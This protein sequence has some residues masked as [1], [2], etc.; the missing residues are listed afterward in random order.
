MS[1]NITKKRIVSPS[2][3]ITILA[4]YFVVPSQGAVLAALGQMS[5]AFPDVPGSY[6]GYVASIVALAQIIGAIVSG[7]I[8][9]RFVK[10]KTLLLASLILYLI[11]GLSPYLIPDGGSFTLLLAT[12]FIF[13]LGLGCFKP[14]AE[15]LITNA[16][17][18][19]NKRAN[20][21][22]F[23]NSA[24][25]IGAVIF[26]T[27]GGLLC[28][29][30]WQTTFLVY[31]AGL[32]PLLAVA[33]LFKEPTIE[34]ADELKSKSKIKIPIV[35]W[36]L[37][38][39]FTCTQVFQYPTFVFLGQF[40]L[41]AGFYNPAVAGTLL[42]SITAVSFVVALAFGGIYRLLGKLTLPISALFVAGGELC[43]YF[44]CSTV[45]MPLMILAVV[46]FGIGITI[47]MAGLSQEV[48]RLVNK[49]TAAAALGFLFAFMNVG[50]FL[51]TPYT[52]MVEGA[53][54]SLLSTL[55]IGP[56]A[57]V[58]VGIIYAAIMFTAKPVKGP[59]EV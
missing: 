46:I 40:M 55:V 34:A 10:Y 28:L 20:V 53:T 16:Y 36:V 39:M 50:T 29:I 8:V 5:V 24:F 48:S 52:V 38:I 35:V 25:S 22:G 47:M 32:V 12:R 43:F 11:A 31:L 57:L 19:E 30:S 33:F 13:G 45:S 6:L 17:K 1:E 14:V 58:I 54:G 15:A 26:Q 2:F 3:M 37:F 18:D 42:S 27:V 59:E 9:G 56:V 51:A 7:F 21:F 44:G 41:E 4:L 49:A 23:G